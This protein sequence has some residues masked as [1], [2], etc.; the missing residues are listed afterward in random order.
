MTVPTLTATG[1]SSSTLADIIAFNWKTG[2]ESK[3]SN[4]AAGAGSLTVRNPGNI[5][6]QIVMEALVT[7]SING[8]QVAAGYVTNIA[9]DYGINSNEDT[10][11]ISLE[12]YLSFIGRGYL[13]NFLF[14]GGTTGYE[15]TRLGNA[16]TGSAATIV[17]VGT[18][19]NT[20][21]PDYKSGD[22]Q[23]LLAQ[24]VATEQGRLH[25]GSTSLS[26][27][28]RDVLLDAST[29]PLSLSHFA[30]TDNDP[31]TNGIAYET[32]TF[33]SLT[34]NYFT[35][36]TIDPNPVA[37][38]QAGTGKR[39]L[40]IS[41]VDDSEE[42][43]QDLANYVLAEFDNNGKTP[44]SV[45]TRNSAQWALDP[46]K[47]A[48]AGVAYRL[49]ITLRGVTYQTII[50]GWAIAA[51][52]SDVAYT[53]YVSGFEQNNFFILDDLIYGVLNSGQL[54]F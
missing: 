39:N 48:N 6:A 30:I 47:V 2:R 51:S 52:P 31:A 22:A 12:G 41:S 37:V 18:R 27:Y 33:A 9:Y 7:V 29:A 54:S 8:T 49:P 21:G 28:G 16:I 53:F 4:F 34:D 13:K 26:F 38:K 5:P 1:P 11:T 25:E 40:Q 42:Q 45:S 15:A 50:E 36:V 32:V 20:Y 46:A 35:Q 24:L 19:S 44:V 10:A 23:T 43:A 14:G 17:D 3:S